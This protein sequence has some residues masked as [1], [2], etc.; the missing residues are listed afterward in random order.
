[1]RSWI[2]FRTPFRGVRAGV[3]F[4]NPGARTYP[5][6]ATGLRIWRIGSFVMW[7]GLAIWL[8]ASRD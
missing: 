5:V 3:T 7:A 1:M 6:S 8:F 4:P 2:S